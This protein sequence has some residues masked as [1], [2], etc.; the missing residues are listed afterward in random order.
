MS[1][2]S[3]PCQVRQTSEE[4]V[5]AL[6]HHH[7][8]LAN[9]ADKRFILVG[10]WLGEEPE[11]QDRPFLT[12]PEWDRVLGQS[13]FGGLD[14]AVQINDEG[15]S[16]ASVMIATAKTEQK[17]EPPEMFL[18]SPN[19]QSR[20]TLTENLRGRF[21]GK[22]SVEN[23]FE[24]DWED[25][26]AVVVALN[27]TT[28]LDL[29]AQGLERMQEIFRSA[30]GILWVV[31]GAS[32][33][34]PM[35]N[36][37]FGLARSMR[38]ENAGLKFS[39]LDLD[40]QTPLPDDEAAE[41]IMRV[42]EMVFDVERP[43][44]VPDVEFR[45]IGGVLRVPRVVEE[46]AKDDYVVRE[47]CPPMAEPQP[48]IQEGRPLKMA[49]GQTGLLD[50]IHFVEDHSLTN[51]LAD[52][53]VELSVQAAGMNFKDI[54][55]SLGQLPFYHEVGIECSGVVT[56]IGSKVSDLRVGDRVCGM[57][58]G[59][60]ATS[61]RVHSSMVTS[62]PQEMH[63]TA[64][65]SIPVV[66]CTAQYALFDAGRLSEGESVLIHAAAGGVGQAAIM[67]AQTVGA[68]L[69]LTVGSIEK[70][71]LLMEQYGIAEDHIFSSRDT[72][73]VNEL[74]DK[75][76]QRGVDVVL[77]SSAGDILHQSWQCLAPL[78]R[79]IEIGK[80]DVS[81]LRSI[82]TPSR[83]FAAPMWTALSGWTNEMMLTCSSCRSCKI[84]TLKWKSSRTLSHS[85]PLTLES[86]WKRS[87]SCSSG[88]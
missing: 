77:N 48:F 52:D 13:G 86:S 54:M 36:M 73:F 79:F 53:E 6:E 30:R 58:K 4:R 12:E 5:R 67:L 29:D 17:T 37:V 44:F 27:D 85:S 20:G 23:I 16:L 26:Y 87:R 40:A 63:F 24:F 3:V 75:T 32:S 69:Y 60:Y 68:D 71:D 15:P 41:A 61:V 64:A 51:P 39:T 9:T 55:I 22:H 19:P 28:W 1:S 49:L 66:Y 35:A 59:A 42:A 57:A 31:R 34:N 8:A 81:L 43:N 65:A 74:M 25:K 2:Y 50:T 14:S 33:Q 47:T 83:C 84:Q 80:R 45:E 78:G 46:K 56:S 70:R 10:W 18:T 38:P 82:C 62:I 88:C 76:N 11:R 72:T 7:R 21:A